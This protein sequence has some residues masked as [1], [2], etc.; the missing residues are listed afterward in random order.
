M[1]STTQNSEGRNK[2]LFYFLVLIVSLTVALAIK[3][4]FFKTEKKTFDDHLEMISEEINKTC[5][6]VMDKETRLDK[7]STVG[8]NIFQYHYTLT[9][10]EKGRFDEA[11][12]KAYLNESILNSIRESE[13]LQYFK[14]RGTTLVYYYSDRYQQELFTLTFTKEE[15]R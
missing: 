15:Y 4:V 13:D 2:R 5:P 7:T 14:D 1:K 9:N 12:L 6:I 3:Q 8:G 11:D 10:L